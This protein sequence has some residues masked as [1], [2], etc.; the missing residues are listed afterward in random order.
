MARHYI[1]FMFFVIA[2]LMIFVMP[3]SSQTQRAKTVDTQAGEIG[4]AVQEHTKKIDID[5][6]P[7]APIEIPEEDP[8]MFEM[9]FEK[10]PHIPS[11]LTRGVT[12]DAYSRF[13]QVDDKKVAQLVMSGVRKGEKA[14]TL[15]TDNFY[16]QFELSNPAL[17]SAEKVTVEG[18]HYELLE[19]LKRLVVKEE[20]GETEEKQ[21][22]AGDNEQAVVGSNS[23]SNDDAAGYQSPDPIKKSP[24]E[25]PSIS[26]EVVTDGCPIRVDIGQ[27]VAVQQSKVVTVEGSD[28]TETLCEDG[29]ARY[30]LERSYAS[31]PDRVDLNA[32][33]ATAQFELYYTGP[34]GGRVTAQDCVDDEDKTYE[35]VELHDGCPVFLDYASLLAVPQATLGYAD[36]VNATVEVRGCAA[37]ETKQAVPLVPTTDGCAVRHA[38]DEELSYQ[39]GHHQYTLDGVT[40]DAGSCID[41]GDTFSH[42]KTFVDEGGRRVCE[43]I[44]DDVSQT[45]TEQY[46]LQITVEGV[47]SYITECR[48]AAGNLLLSSTTDGCE[49]PATWDHDLTSGISYN[50][51]R[52]YYMRN[53]EREYINECITGTRTYTH[54]I[55][56][57]GWL[58]DD[59]S[60]TAQRLHKVSINAPSG[61]YVISESELLSGAPA[62]P[63]SRDRVKLELTG[64]STYEG[65]AA[66]RATR[67]I[68]V[69]SRPDNSEYLKDEGVG[70][71]V[72]EGNICQET[73][74]GYKTYKVGEESTCSQQNHN[75]TSTITIFRYDLV[76]V[77]SKVVVTNG[78]TNAVVSTN[79]TWAGSANRSG[80]TSSSETDKTCSDVSTGTQMYSG[81]ATP[82]AW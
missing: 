65:C 50:K 8:V 27:L 60:L 41:N 9:N 64:V 5:L 48:P 80:A 19:A 18:D 30:P 1:S 21:E 46:R 75:D 16:A 82:P 26:V 81:F 13:V 42:V 62:E 22:A 15:T 4:E 45:V 35:I 52:E 12:V 72:R 74:A 55:E 44:V 6:R 7:N 17:S 29:N 79:Y 34:G 71:P 2:G 37:S 38:F 23:G 54:N 58:T 33:T 59:G 10:V 53:G 20:E 43:P 69:Y 11:H 70:T 25:A 56:L 36:D 61:T 49:D 31:C 14:E 28:R 63:Y 73:N 47:D 77:A 24:A 32:R 66:I 57:A 68:A 40:W 76:R 51:I 39:Q 78:E 3:V 67:S